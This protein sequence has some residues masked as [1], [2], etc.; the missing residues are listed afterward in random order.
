MLAPASQP[1]SNPPGG[2]QE[3]WR[4]RRSPSTI[5]PKS[6]RRSAAR[7]DAAC[8]R[9]TRMAACRA[10]PLARVADHIGPKPPN[11][12]APAL[13]LRLRARMGQDSCHGEV[14]SRPFRNRKGDS[15]AFPLPVRGES[16]LNLRR[17]T[18]VLASR[19]G[20]VALKPPPPF[21][22]QPV[23]KRR[24]SPG[25]LGVIAR[26]SSRGRG[27]ATLACVEASFQEERPTG[28]LP[29]ETPRRCPRGEE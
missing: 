14:S 12:T 4:R 26:A 15:L 29:E 13:A 24:A 7:G 28:L 10:N 8:R 16:V 9:M 5:S 11:L 17:T 27:S 18:G 6:L 20:A 21:E 19:G 25:E 22:E 2:I 23:A 1:V 3:R